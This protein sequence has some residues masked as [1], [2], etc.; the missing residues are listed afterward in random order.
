SAL[1]RPSRKAAAEGLGGVGDASA[2]ENRSAVGRR[3]AR[4]SAVGAASEE[5]GRRRSTAT[6]GDDESQYGETTHRP[7]LAF[8]S[9]HVRRITSP[10]RHARL[11]DRGSALRGAGA[12]VAIRV[13]NRD[14]D[15]RDRPR[16]ALFTALLAAVKIAKRSPKRARN[17][18]AIALIAL[19]SRVAAGSRSR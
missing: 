12:R 7:S 1:G 16:S 11:L 17:R 2:V 5:S 9:L 13:D 19:G 10:R 8:D 4:I 15:S 18:K 3:V 14:G 6:C